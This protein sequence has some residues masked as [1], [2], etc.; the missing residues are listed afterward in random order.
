MAPSRRRAGAPRVPPGSRARR[1]SDGIQ[2][3]RVLPQPTSCDR[4]HGGFGDRRSQREPVAASIHRRSAAIPAAA[5]SRRAGAGAASVS[6][7]LFRRASCARPAARGTARPTQ[8]PGWLSLLGYRRAGSGRRITAGAASAATVAATSGGRDDG[9]RGATGAT[10]GRGRGPGACD[11]RGR[12]VDG[13]YRRDRYGRDA[14]PPRRA[15]A[16]QTAALGAASGAT[17]AR[18][19]LPQRGGDRLQRQAPAR[20]RRLGPRAPRRRCGDWGAAT[21]PDWGA[22]LRAA[23]PGRR[24]RR[25]AATRGRERYFGSSGRRGDR[26]PRPE[27][28]SRWRRTRDQRPVRCAG[29][30]C[31]RRPAS[32]TACFFTNRMPRTA[33]SAP[34]SR[35]LKNPPIVSPFLSTKRSEPSPFDSINSN[36]ISNLFP[37]FGATAFALRTI[38]PIGGGGENLDRSLSPRRP[39]ASPFR[40]VRRRARNSLIRASKPFSVGW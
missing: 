28:R 7:V 40:R 10:S 14:A 38:L 34:P 4:L 3:R 39:F 37:P 18:A 5:D 32:C 29:G 8:A 9:G 13:R 6:I 30:A 23:R 33:P 25:R 24:C 20:A 19:Q 22:R 21:P 16:A 26:R 12:G 36:F 17:R 35:N 2:R 1:S 31:G 27:R 15:A 11:H